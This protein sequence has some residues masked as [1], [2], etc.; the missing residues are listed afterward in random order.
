MLLNNILDSLKNLE[1][2]GKVIL[3][4]GNTD[5]GKSY[6]IKRCLDDAE[7]YRISHNTQSSSIIDDIYL[8][9]YY[10][11]QNIQPMMYNNNSLSYANTLLNLCVSSIHNG[12]MLWFDEINIYDK[13]SIN[14]LTL[15]I[16]KIYKSDSK[17]CL[18]L[19]CNTDNLIDSIDYYLLCGKIEDKYKF[20]L[21]QKTKFDKEILYFFN[22]Y[23]Y[24]NDIPYMIKKQICEACTY[25]FNLTK[26]LI[27][28]LKSIEK[29]YKSNDI[30]HADDI[31]DRLLID[32]LS[33]YITSR[34]NKLKPYEQNI[35]Q[36][37]SLTGININMDLI[38]YAFKMANINDTFSRIEQKTNLVINIERHK[39]RYESRAV[40]RYIDSIINLDDRVKWNIDMANFLLSRFSTIRNK[41][42]QAFLLKNVAKHFAKANMIKESYF[43]DVKYILYAIEIYDYDGIIEIGKKSINLGKIYDIDQEYQYLIC[44]SIAYSYQMKAEYDEAI[45]F[46]D[47]ILHY[48]KS[49]LEFM[50]NYITCL[51]NGGY[52]TRALEYLED[53]KEQNERIDKSYVELIFLKACIYNHLGEDEKFK[54]YYQT[55]LNG[56]VELKNQD[57]YFKI[58]RN[59]DMFLE[60]EMAIPIIL[61]SYNHFSNN[62]YEKAKIAYNLGINYMYVSKYD[63]AEKLFIEADETF[64][65]F[66]S[67]NQFFSNT[68]LAII[69]AIKKDFDSSISYFKQALINSTD[70][71]AEI[72]ILLDIANCHCLKNE[73]HAAYS[74]LKECTV[75]IQKIK[76]STLLLQR[77]L[78][79]AWA[80]YY[81]YLL[82]YENA[83]ENLNEA[84]DIEKNKM[85][86]ET[87]NIVIAQRIL[88]I[89]KENHNK[90]YQ[91]MLQYKDCKLNDYKSYLVD[92]KVTWFYLLFWGL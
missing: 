73:F 87:Y 41:E 82:D 91:E 13:D 5:L 2:N 70:F 47:E 67:K 25:K 10:Q 32:F 84:Y 31:D 17:G 81:E 85:K 28:Y 74:I 75:Q 48:F 9:E 26:A 29:F 27:E 20:K 51:Y 44:N 43:Y 45:K 78:H 33:D 16:N 1:L 7:Y 62:V 38:E 90:E 3:I 37:A 55:A 18:I 40:Y 56:S 65:Q 80:T 46:Y 14:F 60:S 35:M 89:C 92:Q 19:E 72:N 54:Y 36:K 53:I 83:I 24:P 21:T 88:K 15:I 68:G 86:Y 39:Y 61:K 50:F 77:N 59:C 52:Y 42:E 8:S 79:L 12:D 11:N 34:Y 63:L 6:I 4:H 23:L 49:S 69:K 64:S 58:M 30:W 76:E 66:N 22:N 57:L 71:F